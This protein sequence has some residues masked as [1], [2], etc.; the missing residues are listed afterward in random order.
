MR[1]PPHGQKECQEQAIQV[2]PVHH[3]TGFDVPAATF[4]LLKGRFHAHTPGIELDLSA[5]GTLIA[6][7][8]PRF[9]TVWVP[10]QADVGVQRFLLPDPGLCHTSD[11][12][13]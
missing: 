12:H 4:A 3:P 7:E 1:R 5:P 13:A 2:R 8:E 6:D 9:L 10:H 11:S